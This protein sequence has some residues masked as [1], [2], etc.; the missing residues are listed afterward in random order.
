MFPISGQIFPTFNFVHSGT[1]KRIDSIP[2]PR[3]FYSVDQGDHKESLGRCVE[4]CI[5]HERSGPSLS[6]AVLRLSGLHRKGNC[7]SFKSELIRF[8]MERFDLI[9]RPHGLPLKT[10]AE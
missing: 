1:A 8:G 2:R 3:G 6:D 7:G 4:I 10:T 9:E 5:R